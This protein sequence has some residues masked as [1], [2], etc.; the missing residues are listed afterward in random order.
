MTTTE[1][2]VLPDAM[3]LEHTLSPVD[4]PPHD[5]PLEHPLRWTT[6]VIALAC[7]VL[8]PFNATAIRGWAYELAPNASTERVIAA[9]E[10]WYNATAALGLN[11]PTDTM[12][13]WWAA[14]QA[15]RFESA[16]AAQAE[17][18]EDIAPPPPNEAAAEEEEHPQPVSSR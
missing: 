16:D 13:G 17:R 15:A 3:G 11:L 6:T 5:P 18:G 7:A 4:L 9:S 2:M 14:A 12:R 8:L 10:T 1:D